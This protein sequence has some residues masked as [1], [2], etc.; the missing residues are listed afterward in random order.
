ML[1]LVGATYRLQKKYNRYIQIGIE[2]K[3]NCRVAGI[4]HTNSEIVGIPILTRIG[5]G[6][7]TSEKIM[8]PAMSGY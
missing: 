3:K 1:G 4:K 7:I 6:A 2:G 8:K 5:I